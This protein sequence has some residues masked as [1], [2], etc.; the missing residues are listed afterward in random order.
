[1]PKHQ[2]RE[3][4]R[5]DKVLS[6]ALAKA[7][8]ERIASCAELDDELRAAAVDAGWTAPGDGTGTTADRDELT[9]AVCGVF[10]TERAA[11]VR[12]LSEF[13]DLDRWMMERPHDV[14]LVL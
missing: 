2:A 14:P 10:A 8:D 6:R 7:A 12:G 5:L 1:M 3:A 4:E 9:A 13:G 11:I